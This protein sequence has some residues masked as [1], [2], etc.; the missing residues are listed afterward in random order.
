[1]K[2][3][4]LP[5]GKNDSTKRKV[6]FRCPLDTTKFAA[7]R[8]TR[9]NLAKQFKTSELVEPSQEVLKKV[10]QIVFFTLGRATNLEEKHCLKFVRMSHSCRR[11]RVG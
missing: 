6:A 10:K 4:G 1:M 8:D 2:R 11:G 5:F 3:I 7:H 9:N